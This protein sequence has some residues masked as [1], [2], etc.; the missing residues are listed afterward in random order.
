VEW[1]VDIIGDPTDLQMLSEA[2]GDS[3]ISI[4]ERDGAFVLRST[5]FDSLQD[6]NAI[7]TRA[8]EIVISLSGLSRVL[9]D[10]HRPIKVGSVM[11]LR[12]DGTKNVF[13]QVEPISVRAR[14]RANLSITRADGTVEHHSPADPLRNQMEVAGQDPAV[15]KALRL[16]N[17]DVL[18]WVD[19][20]RIYEVVEGD[21]GRS[22]IVASGWVKDSEISRFKHTANSVAASGDQARHGKESTQPPKNPMSLSQAKTLI[23]GLLKAWITSKADRSM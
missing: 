2:M 15:A 4:L 3:D 17:A 6:A 9:L 19:L 16:R 5:E 20:Y 14:M 7:R 18:S 11:M 22:H 21:V 13:I 1:E 10:T 8:Q 12:D 23:D